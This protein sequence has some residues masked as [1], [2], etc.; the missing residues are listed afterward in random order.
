MAAR[1]RSG[2]WSS[3]LE[4]LD[5]DLADGKNVVVHCRQ[6]VGRSG[7]IA[8][9]MLVSKGLRSRAAIEP[10]SAARSGEVPETPQQRRRIDHYAATLAG[11][12]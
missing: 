3:I 11:T 1:P 6:G 8:A 10:V 7:L 5:S 9:C 2:D 12:K 4:N